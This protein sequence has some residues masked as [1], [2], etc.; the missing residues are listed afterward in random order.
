LLGIISSV[1][2]AQMGRFTRFKDKI[3]QARAAGELIDFP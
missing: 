1:I 2:D 3:A